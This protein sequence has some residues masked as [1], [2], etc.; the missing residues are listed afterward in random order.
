MNNSYRFGSP[1]Y[2]ALK[3]EAKLKELIRDLDRVV[4]ILEVDIATEE[5]RA[6]VSDPCNGA[7]PILARKMMAR[8]DNLKETVAALEREFLLNRQG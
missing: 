5:A 4:R 2:A 3:Q 6:G 8:R 1:A 7:Y